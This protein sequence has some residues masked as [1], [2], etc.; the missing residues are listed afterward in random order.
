[1]KSALSLFAFALI[2]L[3]NLAFATT[4]TTTCTSPILT[5]NSTPEGDAHQLGC[6]NHIWNNNTQ[7]HPTCG[8]SVYINPEDKEIFAVALTA[9]AKGHSLTIVY[10][11]AKPSRTMPALGYTITCKV[12]GLY[13]N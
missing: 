13:M 7:A 8:D 11:D 1:M 2:L 9:Q 12:I 3:P 5:P 6:G 4:V 10:N